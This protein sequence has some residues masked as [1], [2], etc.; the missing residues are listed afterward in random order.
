[1]VGAI[2]G[3][4]CSTWEGEIKLSPVS[5]PLPKI[6]QP[7]PHS[8]PADKKVETIRCMKHHEVG[9]GG[10]GRQKVESGSSSRSIA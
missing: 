3:Q 7:P 6:T 9:L 5:F 2:S 10:R 8:H 1:M 4:D